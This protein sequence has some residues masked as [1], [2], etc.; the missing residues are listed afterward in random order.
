MKIWFNNV[1]DTE[2]KLVEVTGNRVRIGRGA[3]NEIVLDSPYIA[4][5]AAVLYKRDGVWEL[6]A[7]GINGVTIGDQQLYDGDRV[8]IRTN[9]TIEDRFLKS[10]KEHWH[11]HGVKFFACPILQLLQV[12]QTRL[13][14]ELQCHQQNRV[15]PNS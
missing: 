13:T 12:L 2:R 3:D 1:V 15:H 9:Q 14:Y 10:H 4:E 8:E 7:L 6:I 5:E 11:A